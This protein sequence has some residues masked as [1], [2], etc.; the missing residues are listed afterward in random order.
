ME[1][2]SLHD[3]SSWLIYTSNESNLFDIRLWIAKRFIEAV[4]GFGAARR[5]AEAKEMIESMQRLPNNAEFLKNAK[6]SLALWKKESR[7]RTGIDVWEHER[8]VAFAL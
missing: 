2:A 7:D 5:M 6:K 1:T 4:G 3:H 8:T